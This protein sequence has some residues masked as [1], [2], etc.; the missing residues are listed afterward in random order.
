LTNGA[1]FIGITTYWQGGQ[2]SNVVLGGQ[3]LSKISGGVLYNSNG[4]CTLWYGVNPPSGD[5]ILSVSHSTVG[6]IELAVSTVF[7]ENVNQL[8]PTGSYATQTGIVTRN[9][10]STSIQSDST[11]VVVSYVGAWSEPAVATGINQSIS[12]SFINVGPSDYSDSYIAFQ[13]GDTQ[14]TSSWTFPNQQGPTAISIGV[15]KAD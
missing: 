6:P 7:L 11:Q 14:V 9:A 8:N 10:L 1:V 13:P 2:A 3:T 12:Q 5:Q 15:R 4:G